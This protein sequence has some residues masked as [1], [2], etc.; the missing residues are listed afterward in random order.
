MNY[1]QEDVDRLIAAVNGVIRSTNSMIG[2]YAEVD[3]MML[4]ELSAARQPFITDPLKDLEELK[5]TGCV[6]TYKEIQ[7]IGWCPADGTYGKAILEACEK[8]AGEVFDEG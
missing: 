3:A 8:R 7:A 5:R 1:K 4:K 2:E 6:L